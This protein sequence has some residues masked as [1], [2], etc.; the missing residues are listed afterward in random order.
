M[1]FYLLPPGAPLAREARY[2]TLDILEGVQLSIHST[3]FVKRNTELIHNFVLGPLGEG[4][5]LC[6][7]YLLSPGAPL[8]RE[9]RYFTLDILEGV[10]LLFSGFKLLCYNGY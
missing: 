7:F 1:S 3:V 5:K 4:A 2:F 9:A 10:Q 6:L 8:A